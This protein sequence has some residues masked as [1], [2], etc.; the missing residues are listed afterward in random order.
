V[1]T[2]GAGV[3]TAAVEVPVVAV[4]GAMAFVLTLLAW[5]F[6]IAVQPVRRWATREVFVAAAGLMVA[7]TAESAIAWL[8]WAPNVAVISIVLALQAA[9]TLRMFGDPLLDRGQR[10]RQ[11]VLIWLLPVA[12]AMIVR[13]FYGAQDHPDDTPSIGGDADGGGVNYGG[14]A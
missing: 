13:A 2:A 1:T 9:A 5:S 12:G 10:R 6:S 3:A 11:L 14:G 7:S 4:A 8:G